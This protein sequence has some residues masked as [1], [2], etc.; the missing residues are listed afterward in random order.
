MTVGDD[1]GRWELSYTDEDIA[2]AR[3]IIAAAVAGRIEERKAFGRSR[4]VV[5]FEDGETIGETGY[6]G[7]ASLVVPQPGWTRWGEG[8]RYEPFGRHSP[9]RASTNGTIFDARRS[10]VAVTPVC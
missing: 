10:V 5:T 6:S 4:V 3:R 1:G 8:I 7:C 9:T 2:L